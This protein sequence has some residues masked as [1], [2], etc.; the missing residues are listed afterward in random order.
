MDAWNGSSPA[1]IDEE[2]LVQTHIALK[3][4]FS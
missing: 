1:G 4:R 3:D 2:I